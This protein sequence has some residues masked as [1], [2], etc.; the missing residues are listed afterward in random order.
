MIQI[1]AIR[2]GGGTGHEHITDVQWQS[3]SSSGVMTCK[4]LI[5]WLNAA[6]TN[7]AV[8]A[9]QAGDVAVLIVEP[10]D[11]AAHV[12]THAK[13]RWADHLLALPRF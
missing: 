10:S 8:V 4:A 3:E 9:G 13:G 5:E 7:Q 12:R 2:L 6:S 1:T 11:G